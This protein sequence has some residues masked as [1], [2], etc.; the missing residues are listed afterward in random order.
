LAPLP[1][2]S[3]IIPVFNAERYVGAAI[4]SVLAQTYRPLEIIAIDDGSTDRGAEVLAGFPEVRWLSQPNSGISAARNRAVALATGDYLAFLDADDLW[5]ADKLAR[6]YAA[7]Q[8]DPDLDL[9]FGQVCQFHDRTTADPLAARPPAPAELQPGYLPSALLL[10]RATFLRVGLFETN[11]RMGE[12][13]SW[14]LRAQEAGLRVAMLP[15]L[16]AWRRLHQTNNGLQQRQSINDYVRILKA[17]LD[18]RRANQP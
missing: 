9:V 4:R 14:Y 3:V 13:T 1:L 15:E 18:R 6:Q 12:F 17:S 10:P 5:V 8:A 7:F 11:W 2:I 16:V